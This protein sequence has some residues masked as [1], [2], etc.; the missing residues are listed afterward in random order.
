M[1]QEGLVRSMLQF[2]A[3]AV[4]RVDPGKVNI[5]QATPDKVLDNVLGLVY[6]VG[7]LVC[8]IVIIIAGIIYA[9]SSGDAQNVKKAKDA[10][11]YAVIG[12]VVIMMA[13]VIT[14][15]V[16]GIGKV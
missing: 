15:Y 6:W 4:H 8:V 16:I 2:F 5:P 14:T 12:L 1:L 3:E 9:T 11:L 7:G 13:F 10:I